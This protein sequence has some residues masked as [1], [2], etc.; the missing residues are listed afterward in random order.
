[1]G[2]EESVDLGHNEEEKEA[3]KEGCLAIVR[4]HETFAQY[5]SCLIITKS[6]G[7]QKLQD[8]IIKLQRIAIFARYGEIFRDACQRLRIQ[9]EKNESP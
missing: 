6:S 3:A 9:A 1:L 2:L 7:A 5:K 8:E 4:M